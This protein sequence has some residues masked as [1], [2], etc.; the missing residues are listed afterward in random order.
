MGKTKKPILFG[1]DLGTDLIS[2]LFLGGVLIAVFMGKV[3]IGF[4][5]SLP[6]TIL[7]VGIL[8]TGKSVITNILRAING[9]I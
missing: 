3:D 6:I 1:I 8:T 5:L 4:S 9:L 7:S 2:F